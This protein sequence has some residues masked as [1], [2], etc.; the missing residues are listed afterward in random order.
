MA[1]RQFTGGILTA[2]R[3]GVGAG[4]EEVAALSLTGL[5][6]ER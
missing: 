4:S 5:G 2:A 1:G 3:V 6:E